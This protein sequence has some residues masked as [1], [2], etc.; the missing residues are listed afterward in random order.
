MQQKKPEDVNIQ[1]ASVLLIPFHYINYTPNVPA[2]PHPETLCLILFSP[3]PG[4]LSLT[5]D[6]NASETD[7]QLIPIFSSPLL[8]L[9]SEKHSATNSEAI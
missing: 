1:F 6:S 2:A 8:P 9:L 7:F 5:Q 4:R 3:F